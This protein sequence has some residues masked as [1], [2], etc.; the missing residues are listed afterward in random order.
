MT[1]VTGDIL[2][3][4][5][6]VRSGKPEFRI[7]PE[8]TILSDLGS[9]PV[10]LGMVVRTNLE[11]LTVGTLKQAGQSYDVVVKLEEIKG[12]D[13]VGEFLF[14]GAPCRPL[15]ILLTIPPVLIG[16]F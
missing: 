12:K 14:P 11:G 9:S 13:Q 7:R 1:E 6:T 8:R 2:E 15:V 3:S 5:T 4:G 10:E 16:M